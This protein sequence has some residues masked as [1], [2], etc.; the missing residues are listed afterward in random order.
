MERGESW[1]KNTPSP[2][3]SAGG[4]IIYDIRIKLVN[5]LQ[6]FTPYSPF[7]GLGGKIV[8]I[9]TIMKHIFLFIFLLMALFSLQA[10]S[11]KPVKKPSIGLHF[12]YN[13]VETAQRIKATSLSD[14]LKTGNWNRANNMQGGFGLD[15]LQGLTPNIDLIGTFN[16]SWADYLLP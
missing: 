12:F 16:G 11:L 13:D 14:V 4:I 8:N 1:N 7:R 5:S 10:Q 6:N 15:Y 2:S 9:H 3:R